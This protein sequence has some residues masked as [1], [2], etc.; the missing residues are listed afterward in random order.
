MS[1]KPPFKLLKTSVFGPDT[2]SMRENQTDTHDT[3][4]LHLQQWMRPE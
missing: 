3:D 2:L 1:T 4:A